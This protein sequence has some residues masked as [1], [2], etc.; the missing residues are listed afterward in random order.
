MS[1]RHSLSEQGRTGLHALSSRLPAPV[2]RWLLRFAR[3]GYWILTPHRMGARIANLRAAQGPANVADVWDQSPEATYEAHG[4]YWMGHPQV[5]RRLNILASGS[6]DRDAY[7]HLIDFLG[8][9]GWRFPVARVLSLGCGHGA[10]E[11][12]LASHGFAERYDGIDLAPRAI[13]EARRLAAERGLTQVH[14][15][16]GDLEQANL[17]EGVFDLVF[18]HQS[19]HHIEDLDGVFAAARR[20]LKPGGV[21]HVHEFVGPDRFQWTDSQLRHIN[22]FVGALPASCRCL[23]S[24]VVR[25]PVTRPTIK[26][27]I[28]VDPSEA[29]RSS[30]IVGA[31]GRHF[32]IIELRELGGSLLHQGL[33]GIA[34]NFDPDNTGDAAR[35]EAFFALEDELMAKGVIGSDFVTVTAVRD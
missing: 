25:G 19:A 30:A 8:A 2:G 20:A 28:A 4:L 27:M 35:L 23:P 21:L 26:Q 17:P 5:A 24:G 31:I 1:L 15:Q 29:I 34:Q 9:Q 12:G 32:R 7:G 14:Y 22:R 11:R 33:S 16:V 6:P 3:L 10:L 18:A 13:A